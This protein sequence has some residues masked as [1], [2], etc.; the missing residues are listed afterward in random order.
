VPLN[1]RLDGP[2]G[3]SGGFGGYAGNY[4]TFY[5]VSERITHWVSVRTRYTKATAVQ[6]PDTCLNFV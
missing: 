1:R 5:S 3:W 2:Q 4:E 6:Y